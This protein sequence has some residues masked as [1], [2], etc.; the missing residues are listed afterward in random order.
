MYQ[1]TYF[2]N[3]GGS[4]VKSDAPHHGGQ[5]G[6]AATFQLEPGEHI[7]TVSGRQKDTIVQLCF[8]TNLGEECAR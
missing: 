2:G 6:G 8:V 5:G 3:S 7:V 1:I 4:V